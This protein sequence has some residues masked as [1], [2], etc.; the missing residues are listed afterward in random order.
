MPIGKSERER[1]SWTRPMQ[2]AVGVLF[3][4]QAIFGIVFNA[5]F[6][7][8]ENVLRAIQA[9]GTTIPAGTDINTVV[10]FG[11]ASA[12]VIAIVIAIIAL[13]V[14][15]GSYLGWRWMFWVAF[16]VLALDAIGAATNLGAV[17]RPSTS[18]LPQ[19]A[20]SIDEVLSLAALGLFIWMLVG[21]IKF[22]PWALKKPGT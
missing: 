3:I 19:W 4:A 12:W 10:D 13:V 16:V 14:A 1:T 2:L 7:T 5:L 6:L 21:L 15:V 18:P 20:V 9:Q 17:S 22:G 8:H 11:I